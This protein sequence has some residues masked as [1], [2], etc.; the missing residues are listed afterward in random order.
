M[1]NILF[2]AATPLLVLTCLAGILSAQAAPQ[3]AAQDKPVDMKKLIA[4]IIGDYSFEIE[5]QFTIIKFTEANGNLYG[6]PEGEPVELLSP[7]EGKPLCFDVTLSDGGEYFVLQFVRNEKGVIDR[8]SL[9]SQGRT[10][11]GTKIIKSSAVS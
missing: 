5:G 3:A 10:V 1:K 6:A 4:E 7:V 8:C 11:E 2:R 9:T